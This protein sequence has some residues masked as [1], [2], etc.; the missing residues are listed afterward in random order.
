MVEWVGGWFGGW[1][2]GRMDQFKPIIIWTHL[3]IPAKTELVSYCKLVQMDKGLNVEGTSTTTVWT[4]SP[5][6][7]RS[8]LPVK[9]WLFT[10]SP[11]TCAN[12]ALCKPK[13]PKINKH[14]NWI[15]SSK[16][17]KTETCRNTE[18]ALKT[19][20]KNEK[21]DELKEIYSNTNTSSHMR[22]ECA[23]SAI[24]AEIS[25]PKTDSLLNYQIPCTHNH[26]CDERWS[27]GIS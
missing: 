4:L 15:E 6:N 10:I 26:R 16:N 27:S 19:L 13:S 5:K 25:W 3:L 14:L 18:R 12:P 11:A 9:G 17:V 24:V 20:Q 21:G 7:T 1:M 22:T 23:N 2:D 8:R